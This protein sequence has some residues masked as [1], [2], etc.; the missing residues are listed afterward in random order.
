MVDGY[1]NLLISNTS[2]GFLLHQC[3]IT[4]SSSKSRADVATT[5]SV[6]GSPLSKNDS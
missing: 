6:L 4:Q 2:Y 3:N 1:K 5:E